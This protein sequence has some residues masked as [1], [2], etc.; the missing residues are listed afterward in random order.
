MKPVS[1]H[2]MFCQYVYV[3]IMEDGLQYSVASGY[4][5]WPNWKFSLQSFNYRLVLYFYIRALQGPEFLG[6][7]CC[8]SGPAS[9]LVDFQARP[10]LGMS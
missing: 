1:D 2:L 4:L 5:V 7:A 8:L 9:F 10:I 3:T 6:P